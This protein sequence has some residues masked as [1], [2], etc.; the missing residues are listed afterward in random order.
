MKK[1]IYVNMKN[2]PLFDSKQFVEYKE[3]ETQT[4]VLKFVNKSTETKTVNVFTYLY[5]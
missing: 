4:P 1:N 3:E 2:N 5:E